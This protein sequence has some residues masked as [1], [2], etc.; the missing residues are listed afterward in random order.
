MNVCGYPASDNSFIAQT[1]EPFLS[2]TYAFA[3]CSKSFVLFLTRHIISS[4]AVLS[5]TLFGLH[6]V[7]W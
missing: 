5:L 1:C 2:V 3:V 6:K 7:V 4:S